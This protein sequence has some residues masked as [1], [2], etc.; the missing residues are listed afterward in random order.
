MSFCIEAFYTKAKSN[1]II[2]HIKSQSKTQMMS[3]L[4][5]WNFMSFDQALR[6][7]TKSRDKAQA[8]HKAAHQH[9]FSTNPQ[10]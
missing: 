8:V 10:N 2:S 6:Q 1:M 9:L 3:N 4:S 7:A 5:Q